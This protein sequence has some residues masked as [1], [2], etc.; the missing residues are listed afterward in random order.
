M[1]AAGGPNLSVASARVWID[2]LVRCGLT[3]LCLA[4]GSRSAPL[5][6]AALAD[7]RVRV[8]VRIDERSAAFLALGLARGSGRPVAVLCTSGTAAASFFPAVIEA[9]RSR[10]PLIVLTADRP[11]ELRHAAANQTIDQVKLYG[12]AVRWFCE[13]GVAEDLPSAVP[14]WR[15]TVCRAWSEASGV[16]AAPGPVHCNLAFREPLVPGRGDPFSQ[17]MDGR[18]DGRA[19]T[20]AERRRR[21]PSEADVEQLADRVEDA[22]RGALVVGDGGCVHD[23]VLALARS[24]GWPVLAE[25]HSGARRGSN[26]IQHVG[27]LLRDAGFAEGH[28]P[29]LVVTVGRVVLSKALMGW[30]ADAP[31]VLVDPDGAHVDPTRSVERVIAADPELLGAA[32]TE[33][34]GETA[35]DDAWL[36]EWLAADRAVAAAVDGVLDE[37]DALTEPVVARDLAALLPDGAV[38]TVASSMPIRDLDAFMTPRDGVRFVAN[39]GASGID[40]FVSTAVGVALAHD[41][42]AYALAGDLSLLHDQNGLLIAAGEPRPDLVLVVVNNDGGGIFSFLPQAEHPEGFERVFGT[43]HG[44][45][46]AHVAMAAGCGHRRAEDR[47]AFRSALEAAAGAGGIQIVEVRTDRVANRALHTRIVQAAHAALARR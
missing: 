37:L 27:L 44:V 30:L 35:P 3:D 40:G 7:G 6:M 23:A 22:R 9:D 33:R 10:V 32:L 20:V 12:D 8:H 31:Q 15:S 41:G 14:Y 21:L 16:G 47:V 43:P 45:D 5:A 38:C 39:R 42:P 4:P 11:P 18:P 24:R 26:A 36:E 28:R 46:L 13:V 17:A 29:D 1:T 34:V 2:E 19:W 25:A